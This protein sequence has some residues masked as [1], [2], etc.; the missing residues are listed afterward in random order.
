MHDERLQAEALTRAA[1]ELSV[2]QVTANPQVP[3]TRGT[4]LFRIGNAQVNAEFISETAR[5]DLNAAPKEL[6]CGP[7]HWPRR[8]ARGRADYY[9]DRILGW[10]TPPPRS[11][12][13]E[14]GD[15]PHGRPAF[16]RRA[17]RR[18]SMSA[19]SGWCS[20]SPT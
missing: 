11:R 17:A 19:S 3:L 5:I 8:A 6:L 9:A 16:T 1:L 2:Y 13:N 4:F 7:V 18:S 20:A 15:L 14:A 10:R 12:S